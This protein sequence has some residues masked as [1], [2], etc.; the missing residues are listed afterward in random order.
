MTL[1]MSAGIGP[2]EDRV[3]FDAQSLM[4]QRSQTLWGN[5]TP[6][7]T[8]PEY[9]VNVTVTIRPPRP[10]LIGIAGPKR[11]GKDTL[12]QGLKVVFNLPQDSFAGP[13][14]RFIADILGMTPDQLEAQKED[15]IEWLD[16]VTPRQMM[17]TVGTE[18]GRQMVHPDL[19]V[20]SLMHRVHKTGGIISD[21]RFSNEAEAIR[22]RGG[23]V[24]Q[25][26][27]PGTGQGD[28][29]LSETPLPA[30]LVDEVIRNDSLPGNMIA[31]AVFALHNHH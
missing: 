18:W 3:E 23:V 28:S 9:P 1:D 2:A 29:H 7:R 22:E 6:S 26:E 5:C 30:E 17:Q 31:D 20:R 10:V 14:R 12:A 8:P 25:V 27:R 16:G 21:V 11:A 19:W 24:L 4:V 15:P 13:I